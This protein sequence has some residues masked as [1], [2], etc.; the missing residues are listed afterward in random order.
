L[1]II[2]TSIYNSGILKQVLALGHIRSCN[3][4]ADYVRYALACR[5]ATNPTFQKVLKISGPGWV[6]HDK[7]KHIGH[8]SLRS[9]SEFDYYAVF[10]H[11]LQPN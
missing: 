3:K 10:N 11:L 8:C 9:G 5:D 6:R 7:L 4:H 2:S 1:E